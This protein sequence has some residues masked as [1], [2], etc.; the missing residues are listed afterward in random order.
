MLS[1]AHR[2]SDTAHA[3][4]HSR[5]GRVWRFSRATFLTLFVLAVLLVGARIALPYILRN[6]INDRLAKIPEYRGSVESVH[7]ALWRGAYALR[8]LKIV[9]ITAG[10]NVPFFSVKNIDFSL[11]WRELI[12]RKIVSD[13]TLESPRLNFVQTANPET[14]QIAADKRWQDAIQDIFPVDITHLE[15][16][17]GRVRYQNTTLTPNVDFFVNDMRVVVTGLRNRPAETNDEMPAK[18]TLQGESVGKGHLIVSG[19]GEPL[20]AAPRFELRVTLDQV[21]LPALNEFLRAYAKVDVS[22]GTLKVYTEMAARDG[23]FQG[24]VKP[25]LSDLN[26][27]SADDEKNGF[28]HR[29]WEWI[30]GGTMKL[31]K[32]SDTKEVATRIPFAGEFGNPQV[33][34]WKTIVAALR[35]GFVEALPAVL[36]HSVKSDKIP[37]PGKPVN[38]PPAP[39]A[40]AVEG[41]SPAEKKP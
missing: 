17:D 31:L 3:A 36:E 23:R 24:Y 22:T 21:N 1:T 25:F 29:L 37:P 26:F 11:A 34:V 7:V 15:I 14:T 39:P 30:V 20:A 9:K 35:N 10:E 28:G 40:S 4:H 33:G 8:N 19:Q 18:L 16:T 12:H 27:K 32:N 41:Q 6:A 5:H 13:I 2:P 38:L